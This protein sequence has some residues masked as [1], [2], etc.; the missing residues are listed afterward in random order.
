MAK[1]A[2]LLLRESSMAWYRGDTVKALEIARK[3]LA[4]A[5]KYGQPVLTGQARRQV[6]SLQKILTQQRA[7]DALD[8]AV[9]AGAR[10]R[11]Y[12]DAG[13]ET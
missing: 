11:V 4:H 12:S 10:R 8:F 6:E 7:R 2:T 5:E 9:E 3:A 13:A 1:K